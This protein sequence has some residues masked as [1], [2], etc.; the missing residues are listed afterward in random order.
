MD[1]TV[2]S[3]DYVWWRKTFGASVASYSG[4]DGDGDAV[5][6]DD[7]HDVWQENFGES[8][9]APSP[10]SAVVESSTGALA[11]SP[12][13]A[14]ARRLAHAA[15]PPADPVVRKLNA[16]PRLV[17]ETQTSLA[18]RDDSLA[19]WFAASEH[20]AE[21]PADH[22]VLWHDDERT[23]EPSTWSVN[24]LDVAFESLAVVAEL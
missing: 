4:A 24:D 19:A 16:R 21:A 15:R 10:S 3:A 2:N 1:G 9:P 20:R 8:L 5:I 23:N 14:L 17:L 11:T 12:V 13:A 6:N 7:D 22:D 18:R